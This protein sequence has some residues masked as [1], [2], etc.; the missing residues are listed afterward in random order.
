MDVL[1]AMFAFNTLTPEILMGLTDVRVDHLMGGGEFQELFP[2]IFVFLLV[3]VFGK[4]SNTVME[5]RL[6][7]KLGVALS[8]VLFLLGSP[9]V[10]QMSEFLYFNF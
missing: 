4:N 8:I 5:W 7:V 3:S 1:H 10:S 9:D 2:W 6:P